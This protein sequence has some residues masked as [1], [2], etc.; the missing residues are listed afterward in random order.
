MIRLI[1]EVASD[2]LAYL[3]KGDR[4]G[5]NGALQALG[6]S[7]SDVV[8]PKHHTAPPLALLVGSP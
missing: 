4:D 5:S 1:Y 3:S 8:V 7:C 6:S 2:P